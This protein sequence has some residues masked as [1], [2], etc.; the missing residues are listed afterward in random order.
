MSYY[1]DA[2]M[3]KVAEVRESESYVEAAKDANWCVAMEE[4]MRALDANDTWDLIDPHRHCK[5]IECTMLIVWLIGTRP[6][7]W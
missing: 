4:E 2:Y 5:P 6:D 7:W 1:E 3:T